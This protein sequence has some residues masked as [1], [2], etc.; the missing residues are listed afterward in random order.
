[1][2]L[3]LTNREVAALAQVSTNTLARLEIGEALKDRTVKD[4]RRAL[5]DA[6]AIFYDDGARIGV[7]LAKELSAATKADDE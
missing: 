4:I 7:V 3:G 1:M 6:G 2:A 5:E